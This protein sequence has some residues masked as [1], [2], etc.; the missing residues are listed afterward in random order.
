MIITSKSDYGIRAALFL[1]SCHRRVRLREISESQH[2]PRSICA[3]V[4]RRLVNAEIVHSQAGPAGG[5]TLARPPEDIP[6]AE[7][8][9]ASDRNICIFRCVDE[10]DCDCEFA[11]RCAFQ[12][13]LK[14]F[15][16]S[17]TDYLERLS[18]ADLRDEG[19]QL[20]EFCMTSM[21]GKAR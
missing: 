8:L 6:V 14:G 11:G 17:I 7:I 9:T 2:I 19:S 15:G 1:A 12:L 20:P 16:R 5:Y 18:L 10:P 3:H 13:V 4:M 21:E